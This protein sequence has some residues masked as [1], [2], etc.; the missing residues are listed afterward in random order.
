MRAKL[1]RE[2]LGDVLK[3]K[4]QEDIEKLSTEELFDA[5]TKKPGNDSII[6]GIL[7]KRLNRT[8][9]DIGEQ[10]KEKRAIEAGDYRAEQYI[11]DWITND[12]F[13]KLTQYKDDIEIKFDSSRSGGYSGDKDVRLV[14]K[15]SPKMYTFLLKNFKDV[16]PLYRSLESHGSY[17]SHF[18][19]DWLPLSTMD[20]KLLDIAF[21]QASKNRNK[22]GA[23]EFIK[24][25]LKTFI[26]KDKKNL[27]LKFIEYDPDFS[28]KSNDAPAWYQEYRTNTF[29]INKYGDIMSS[30]Y[31]KERKERLKKEL[32]EL[33][34]QYEDLTTSKPTPEI[35]KRIVDRYFD[36]YK[37]SLGWKEDEWKY[38]IR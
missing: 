23:D 24:M 16:P 33:Q 31:I 37:E 35:K 2:A 7:S 29:A 4:S 20:E 15:I 21:K 17:G 18:A 12:N 5:A 38:K 19:S 6:I 9:K 26:E 34:Q 11:S 8:K 1:L 28:Y 32:E 30:R 13:D 25:A 27:F 3:P 10:I 14:Y 22:W 36:N